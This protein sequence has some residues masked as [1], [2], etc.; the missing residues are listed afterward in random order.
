MKK[1]YIGVEIGASKHQI[2]LS[3]ENGDYIFKDSGKVILEE[4]ATGILEW[5]REHIFACIDSHH[6]CAV[7]AIAIGF[8]GIIESATGTSVISVQVDGWKDFNIKKWFE[9]TFKLPAFVLND[10]VAGGFA[11]YWNGTGKGLDNFFYTNIGSGIGGAFFLDGKYYDGSGYGAAYFGHTYIPDWTT[12]QPNSFNKVETLCS[13]FG[14]QNRL[15]RDGYVPESSALI[16]MCKGDRKTI[17]TLMLG[18]AAAGGDKFSLEEIDRV[19][20][21]YSIGLSNV[22]TL[23]HPQV[24]S[25]G[26]GVANMGEILLEPIRRYTDE[27]VFISAKGKYSIV[28][29]KYGD[30]AV[31]LGAAMFASKSL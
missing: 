23:I 25:I 20:R 28:K 3:D 7:Q 24:I 9:D 5:M 11:E 6:D 27:K 30:D 12:D 10:T 13:G 2:Y 16:E 15:R 26:G 17:T 19:A 29:C 14:I 8:G 21:G 4:G 22:I 1:M 18:T 31:P